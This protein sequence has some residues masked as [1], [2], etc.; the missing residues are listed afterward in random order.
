MFIA[1]TGTPGTGKTSVSNILK[2]DGFDVLSINEI[3]LKNKFI[4]GLDRKRKTKILDLDRLNDYILKNYSSDNLIFIEGHASHL[5]ELI[6]KVIILRC[7]PKKL[8]NRLEKK[9]W[10]KLKIR[11]NIEAEALDVIL[12]EVVEIFSTDFIFEID[13]SCKD[14]CKVA[15]DVKNIV[16]GKTD[17]YNFGNIDWSS[18]LF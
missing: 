16:D 5:L 1:L 14:I 9:G 11:E 6:S 10:D 17:D 12:C 2:D 4:S 8:Q 3:A 18:D 7:H 13:T 15:E